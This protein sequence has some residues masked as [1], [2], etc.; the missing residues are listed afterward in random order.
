MESFVRIRTASG[1]YGIPIEQVLA[2]FPGS[3]LDPAPLGAAGSV[4]GLITFRG[5]A[6]SVVKSADP[7]P[8]ETPMHILIVETN[9]RPTGL[10]VTEVTGISRIS[11]ELLVDPPGASGIGITAAAQTDDGLVLILDPAGLVG[12]VDFVVP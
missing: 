1:S 4:V 11:S 3:S 8:I 9:G 12:P 6:I 10:L 5:E 2:V 7:E